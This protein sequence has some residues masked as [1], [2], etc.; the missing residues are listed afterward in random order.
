MLSGNSTECNLFLLTVTIV[1]MLEVRNH[2]NGSGVHK[3]QTPSGS[4]LESSIQTLVTTEV[5]VT[6][7]TAARNIVITGLVIPL[8]HDFTVGVP[9]GR[10]DHRIPHLSGDEG[11]QS[12]TEPSEV[13]MGVGDAE[14]RAM[15]GDNHTFRKGND[16][17][18]EVT[19][20]VQASNLLVVAEVLA[21]GVVHNP[22]ILSHDLFLRLVEEVLVEVVNE[23]GLA[24]R[25]ETEVYHTVPTVYTGRTRGEIGDTLGHALVEHLGVNSLVKVFE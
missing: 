24:E 15:D 7:G 17:D 25:L 13:R 8:V 11:F 5:K 10:T 21:K 4:S 23:P 12:L 22:G 18:R 16:L 9:D 1:V 20:A 19:Q 2:R 6:E 14:D 3:R